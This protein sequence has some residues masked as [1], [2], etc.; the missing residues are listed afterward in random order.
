MSR[1]KEYWRTAFENEHASVRFKGE[2]SG[3]D[4]INF[5]SSSKAFE[6]SAYEED[7]FV[8]TFRLE[9]AGQVREHTVETESFFEEET[10]RK[11]ALEWAVTEARAIDPHARFFL[12]PLDT[13]AQLCLHFDFA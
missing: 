12:L 9:V 10:L 2:T 1:E 13:S 3:G 6:F 11:E 7:W 5:A 8:W 4:Q